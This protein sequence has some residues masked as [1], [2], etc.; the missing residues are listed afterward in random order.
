[1]KRRGGEEQGNNRIKYKSSKRGD[2]T[3][4]QEEMKVDGEKRRS[5]ER[6]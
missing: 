4:K 2:E 5:L 3:R 1:M 6:S